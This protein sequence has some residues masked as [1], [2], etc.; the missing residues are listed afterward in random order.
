MG[1]G[2][3]GPSR[4][5]ESGGRVGGSS[6]STHGKKISMVL[7]SDYCSVFF[8]KSTIHFALF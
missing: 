6:F 2:V 3:E 4:G 1:L 5:A 8:L 7:C